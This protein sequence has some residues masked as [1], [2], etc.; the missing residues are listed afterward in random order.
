MSHQSIIVS[1][2]FKT[3]AALLA[4]CRGTILV[5]IFLHQYPTVGQIRDGGCSEVAKE[6]FKLFHS[7]TRFPVSRQHERV[8][9]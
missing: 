1:P 2:G 9:Q 7:W 5:L 6:L 4:R 8:H 3:S